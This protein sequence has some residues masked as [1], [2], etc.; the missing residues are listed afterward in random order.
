MPSLRT[1]WTRAA[2]LL[3]LGPCPRCGLAGRV[4]PG[5]C[6]CRWLLLGPCPRRGGFA[7]RTR[8][9]ARARPQQA[10]APADRCMQQQ[11]G[12]LRLGAAGAR[13]LQRRDHSV[14]A[15]PDQKDADTTPA[16]RVRGGY[17]RALG[18][19]STARSSSSRQPAVADSQQQT[20]AATNVSLPPWSDARAG[21]RNGVL[22]IEFDAGMVTPRQPGRAARRRRSSAFCCLTTTTKLEWRIQAVD[23]NAKATMTQ[24][25]GLV[26]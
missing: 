3:L 4:P 5:C 10:A 6:R 18:R 16:L 12:G 9:S 7:T 23:C 21:C 11:R 17:G 15:L 22:R 20:A 8:G 24:N 2:R 25:S 14:G 26:R 13:P 1:S 19:R